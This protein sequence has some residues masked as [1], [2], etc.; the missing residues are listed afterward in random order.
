VGLPDEAGGDVGTGL[1]VAT[2]A[3]EA[4]VR[5]ITN[6]PVVPGA[7]TLIPPR[8]DSATKPLDVG[9][10]SAGFG[11]GAAGFSVVAFAS[12]GGSPLG[13]GGDLPEGVSVL[14]GSS[15]VVGGFCAS[16]G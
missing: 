5:G 14:A 10:I 7:A 1:A 3:A 11:V 15:A 6:S 13:L 16:V 8:L 9:E 12:R 2:S 4:A